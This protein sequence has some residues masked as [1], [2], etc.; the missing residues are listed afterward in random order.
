MQSFTV[1]HMVVSY[2]TFPRVLLVVLIRGDSKKLA[3]LQ[4]QMMLTSSQSVVV[5]MDR[6]FT[7]SVK[8]D[9]DAIGITL[10]H[11]WSYMELSYPDS[12]FFI[13]TISLCS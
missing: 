3:S 5:A 12:L 4:G 1:T 2:V 6:I 9:G 11:L 7:G 8:L 10:S 13:Y